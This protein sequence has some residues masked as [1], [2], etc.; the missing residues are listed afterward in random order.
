MLGCE[1]VMQMAEDIASL[2]TMHHK[3]VEDQRL[4]LLPDY[5]TYMAIEQQ[6]LFHGFAAREGH[7]LVGYATFVTTP[8]LHHRSNKIAVCDMIYVLPSHR[9][10]FLGGKLLKFAERVLKDRGTNMM[11][12]DTKT[13]H[14]FKSILTRIGY[15]ATE[16]RYTKHIGEQ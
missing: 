2:I 10:S 9:G 11:I 8:D 3:E 6:G 5:N 7:R 13:N 1:G 14:D 16:I 15:E 12:V 4:T